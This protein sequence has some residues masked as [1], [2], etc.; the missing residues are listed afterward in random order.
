MDRLSIA[1]AHTRKRGEPACRFH[2][3]CNLL[4]I[5]I[6]AEVRAMLAAAVG[7]GL[8]NM[9]GILVAARSFWM[10]PALGRHLVLILEKHSIRDFSMRSSLE[11]VRSDCHLTGTKSMVIHLIRVGR[12]PFITTSINNL[13]VRL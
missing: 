1:V 2:K 5:P 12:M 13:T 9:Q 6:R 7:I 3:T 8:T 4:S 11:A 10:Q